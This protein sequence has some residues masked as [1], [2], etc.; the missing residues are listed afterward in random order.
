MSAATIG[1]DYGTVVE[2]GLPDEKGDGTGSGDD[3]VFRVPQLRRHHVFPAIQIV[4]R[5]HRLGSGRLPL[6]IEHD[7][8]LHTFLQR[9]L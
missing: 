9:I 8:D 3:P 4:D 7:D 6:A 2:A 1:V 5:D